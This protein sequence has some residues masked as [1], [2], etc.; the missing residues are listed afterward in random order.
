MRVRRKKKKKKKFHP[1]NFYET[2]T[3]S[4]N[5]FV[6]EN[7]DLNANKTHW[8][9]RAGRLDWIIVVEA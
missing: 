1:S 3:S 5:W 7:A 2:L 4:P 8:E 6:S 9:Q